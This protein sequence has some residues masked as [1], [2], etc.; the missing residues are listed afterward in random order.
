[1]QVLL[2]LK[3]YNEYFD[4]LFEQ[5][6]ENEVDNLLTYTKDN[7]DAE[8]A[9]KKRIVTESDYEN[10]NFLF[11][12]LWFL[13]KRIT[14]FETYPLRLLCEIIEELAKSNKF[15]F[16][17]KIKG[18]SEFCILVL[19]KGMKIYYEENLQRL[20]FLFTNFSVRLSVKDILLNEGF[21]KIAHEFEKNFSSEKTILDIPIEEVR[22]PTR[23]KTET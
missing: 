15:K 8:N 18:L 3:S 21:D 5:K 17:E 13:T 2:Q 23:F 7:K 4:M 10:I 20:R 19:V 1:M 9:L 12:K 6:S 14:K 22:T 11:N 16:Y